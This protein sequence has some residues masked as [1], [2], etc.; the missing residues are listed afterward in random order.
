[1]RVAAVKNPEASSTAWSS[2]GASTTAKAWTGRLASPWSMPLVDR[3]TCTPSA[4]YASPPVMTKL[5]AWS[6]SSTN[7][8]IAASR[9]RRGDSSVGRGYP[10]GSLD[11]V[12]DYL[13]VAR[14][15]EQR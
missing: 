11:E 2:D 6:S 14:E 10:L 12:E 8:V 15:R 4:P 3:S 9:A 13:S 7:A 1:M 5:P